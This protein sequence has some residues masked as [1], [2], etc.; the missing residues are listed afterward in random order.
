M[1]IP[2][3]RNEPK[4]HQNKIR[5]KTTHTHTP[6]HTH[7]VHQRVLKDAFLLTKLMRIKGKCKQQFATL[8]IG[9][10]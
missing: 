1:K 10:H 2:A 8:V 5:E 4:M 3:K 6:P 9:R 7:T